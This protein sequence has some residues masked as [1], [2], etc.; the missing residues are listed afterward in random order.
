MK[1]LV[2][3]LTLGAIAVHGQDS[4][5][6]N[7]P[8]RNRFKRS[9]L[10]SDESEGRADKRALR[11]TA[12]EDRA[13]DLEFE[14]N[15]G[16]NGISIGNPTI[17]ATTL[18]KIGDKRQIVFKPLKAGSTTV[19]VRDVDGTLRLVFNV[20][21]TPSNLLRL[22]GEIRN[23]LR[24]VEGLD[25]R[26]VG[27]NIVIEG[28]L[29]TPQDFGKMVT[30]LGDKDYVDH[31]INMAVLSPLAMQVLAKRIQDDVNTFAPN[32]RTR[33]VNGVIFLEGTVDNADQAKRTAKVASTYLPPFRPGDLMLN[34]GRPV[35]PEVQQ[36]STAR[37]LI[38]NFIVINPPPP[39]KQEKL[40]RVTLHFV[41]LAKDYNKYFG[42]KWEP[43]FTS[44]P[45]IQVGTTATGAVGAQSGSSFSA[46]L[47]SLFPKLQS[48]QEAGFA[49]ILRTGTVVVRSGQPAQLVEQTQ[50]P[51]FQPGAN[52]AIV[53]GQSNVGLEVGV[54]PRILG[55]SE[56]IE[57]E[58]KM[59]QITLVARGPAGGPPITAAHK[60]ETRV[61]IKSNESAAVAAV[62]STDVGTDFNKDA[63]DDS[64]TATGD[65]LFSLKRSKNFRKKKSQFV[66]F[67]TPQILD[68]ASEGT[69]DLKKNFRVRVK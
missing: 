65:P 54:T 39:R 42:F 33:V 52:G 32:V 31:I 20:I 10:T 57:M 16:A 59:N 5:E 15:A 6:E 11:L 50:F 12:G 58:L 14:A 49:R 9:A 48:A 3:I 28:E 36:P 67:V 63:P 24:D 43:G 7:A 29:L 53:P 25:I 22:S 38:Q 56:D 51:F 64:L 23:L 68:N 1:F 17:V 18:A 46:T 34:A 47:S 37:S 35:S 60:V 13:V 19:T 44:E 8:K 40:V 27:N 4:P 62:N 2:L 26:V 41:E 61:Y 30:V 55:Q 45:Q 69:E 66:V 21:I